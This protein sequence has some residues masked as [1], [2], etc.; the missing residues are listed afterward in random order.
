MPRTIPSTIFVE[1]WRN[2]GE[3]GLDKLASKIR[4]TRDDKMYIIGLASFIKTYNSA[5]SSNHSR[6]NTIHV[7]QTVQGLNSKR[8]DGSMNESYSSDRTKV[9]FFGSQKSQR[10]DSKAAMH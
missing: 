8:L 5:V 10:I 6:T 2:D 7:T 1:R 4:F 3:D 9:V